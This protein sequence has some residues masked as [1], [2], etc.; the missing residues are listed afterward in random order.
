MDSMGFVD[1][2]WNIIKLAKDGIGNVIR[3]SDGI[4]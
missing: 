2:Y 3:M 1:L 4:Y